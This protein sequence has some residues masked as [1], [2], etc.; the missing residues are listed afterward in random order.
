MLEVGGLLEEARVL[1][2][3]VQLRQSDRCSKRRTD[4]PGLLQLPY[5]NTTHVQK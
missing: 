2:R 5:N 4:P 3:P 1:L